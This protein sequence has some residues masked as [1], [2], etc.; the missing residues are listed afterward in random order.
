MSKCWEASRAPVGPVGLAAFA[1]PCGLGA[2]SVCSALIALGNGSLGNQ[3]RGPRASETAAGTQSPERQ[4]KLNLVPQGP[5]PE[6]TVPASRVASAVWKCG[7]A[8]VKRL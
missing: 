2:T 5:C 6:E 3:I 8:I 1:E 7:A 4:W